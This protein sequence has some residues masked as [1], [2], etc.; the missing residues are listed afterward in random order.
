MESSVIGFEQASAQKDRMQR[1]DCASKD[2]AIRQ[3]TAK[4]H[5]SI[6]NAK[7]AGKPVLLLVSG[8]S[9]LELLKERMGDSSLPEGEKLTICALDDRVYNDPEINTYQRI[10]ANNSYS[11]IY[12]A[13]AHGAKFIETAMQEG[14]KGLFAVGERVNEEIIQWLAEHP[15]GE[16]I[17]TV[18]MGPDGHTAG[19][20]PH[21]TRK[22]MR[23][24]RMTEGKT[25]PSYYASEIVPHEVNEYA[26]RVSAT[27]MLLERAKG[28][29]LVVSEEKQELLERVFREDLTAAN[30]N[31]LPALLW[32]NMSEVSVFTSQK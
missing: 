19:I 12:Q 24:E 16:I 4:L 1:V 25:V 7:E 27:N 32:R 31:E 29:A 5:E 17:A 13:K 18:G 11:L 9:A 8:G 23:E 26:R 15:D 20:F 2:E 28:I 22:F 3:G 14:D 30:I 21:N 6:T 10:T